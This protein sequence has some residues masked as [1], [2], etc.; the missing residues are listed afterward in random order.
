MTNRYEEVDRHDLWR[1]IGT[2]GEIRGI[3]I[4]YKD[5]EKKET[6]CAEMR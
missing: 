1:E 4:H 2:L 3:G 5:L 6:Y